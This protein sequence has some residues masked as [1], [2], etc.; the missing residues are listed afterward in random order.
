[1]RFVLVLHLTPHMTRV[2]PATRKTTV[3]RTVHRQITAQ[4]RKIPHRTQLAGMDM[5]IMVSVDVIDAS[6]AQSLT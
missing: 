3:N 5:E 6:Q 2:I 1:M 4:L